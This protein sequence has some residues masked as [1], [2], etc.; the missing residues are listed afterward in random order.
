MN[1]IKNRKRVVIVG[2]GLSGIACG[3]RL[4]D[5]ADVVIL[6]SQDQV[7][8]MAFSVQAGDKW[9][10]AT[11]HH[12]LK[13]DSVTRRFISEFGLNDEL[14]WKKVK[15][16]YYF[17]NKAY[18][19]TRPHHILTFNI[20]S[21]IEKI[22]FALLGAE[23]M[24]RK[25]WSALGDEPADKWIERKLGA[26]AKEVLF[27]RLSEMKFGMPLSSVS[28]GWLGSR[29]SENSKNG[30]WFA[31][32]RPG[33]KAL[34]DRMVEKFLQNGTCSVNSAVTEIY[35]DRVI[36]ANGK[37]FKYDFLVS[38]IPPPELLKTQKLAEKLDDELYQI[39]YIPLA[40]SIFG[41]KTNL[42]DYYW[43]VYM[44]PRLSFGGIF[45]HTI[46]CPQAG[47]N[48][49]YVYYAFSYIANTSH[50]M[51]QKSA[52]ELKAIHIADINKLHPGF[53]EEW[54]HTSKIRYAEPFFTNGYKSPPVRSRAFPNLFYAGVYR[55]YPRTRTMHTALDSGEETALELSKIL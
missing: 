23:C 55:K 20:L 51:W 45:N 21:P 13:V 36:T 38:T 46:L 12:V 6:E 30:E 34:I 42:S 44:E 26:R 25:D 22:R 4:M 27:E 1:A 43:N 15:I 48:G 50:Q 49:E 29:L 37:E 33:I 39:D 7:G 28:A 8:G 41:S 24:I 40:C 17:G 11:Y 18:V 53:K 32:P 5:K 3:L 2:G 19:I 52:D 31:Y 54:W 35:P 10:P 9:F 47:V 14:I 16:A